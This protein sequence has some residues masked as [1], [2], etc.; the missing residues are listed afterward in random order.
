MLSSP[1]GV[2]GFLEVY[3]WRRVEGCCVSRRFELEGRGA[4]AEVGQEG[5]SGSNRQK[6]AL[7]RRGVHRNDI[8][9]SVHKF[10]PADRCDSNDLPAPRASRSF[11]CHF[12]GHRRGDALI[13]GRGILQ[14]CSR[15]R[16][17][18]SICRRRCDL[19]RCWRR[20]ALRISLL[21]FFEGGLSVLAEL[22]TFYCRASM[23]ALR[24]VEG[25]M[26][27]SVRASSG[28]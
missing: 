20:P 17:I 11:Q 12:C 26:A 14:S 25:R 22:A 7:C 21:M 19:R 4:N 3:L 15:Q 10:D 16:C 18:R 8:G 1:K 23:T 9:P 6:S 28:R 13:A 5:L 27:A 24:V 2:L